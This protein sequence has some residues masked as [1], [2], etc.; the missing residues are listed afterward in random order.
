MLVTDARNAVKKRLDIA[1]AV[2]TF[3]S[4]IDQFVAESVKRLY[5]FAQYEYDPQQV[6]SGL[7]IVGGRARLDLSSLSTPVESVRFVESTEGDGYFSPVEHSQHGKFLTIDDVSSSVS[8]F[9]I[10]GLGKFT[11]TNLYDYLEQAVV[12]YA[13]AEFFKF[14][15]GN[16]R[17]YN[18][19][20]ANGRANVDSMQDLADYYE[21]Q[22][23]QYLS[24][25]ATL[26]GQS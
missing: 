3:D 15:I 12:Y 11:L 23:N 26:Y 21:Q 25:R 14:L 13:C 17:K 18:V 5:P 16:K 4:D 10:Y 8:G 22:A 2:T 1:T 9:Q 6:T 19:Y 7:N 20:M 24:D